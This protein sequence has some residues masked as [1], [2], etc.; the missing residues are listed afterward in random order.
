MKTIQSLIGMAIAACAI[1]VGTASCNA[2]RT[3][4]LSGDT[5]P[6]KSIVCGHA[7]L[8][9]ADEY[10]NVEWEENANVGGLQVNVMYGI[11]DD[12]GNVNYALKQIETLSDGYFET[13]I[14]CPVGQS[15]KVK[16]SCKVLDRNNAEVQGSGDYSDVE[17]WFYSEVSKD[18]PCGKAVYFA[19]DMTS[20]ANTGEG[21]LVQPK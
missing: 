6:V 17:A 3:T 18:V 5:L 7:R 12:K 13:E 1:L 16:V 10:G 19:L 9:V 15:L 21:G 4:E 8:F 11:P 14:G 20:S 2:V